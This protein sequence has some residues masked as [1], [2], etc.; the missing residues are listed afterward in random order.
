VD[1][2]DTAAYIL[3]WG[4]DEE[5]T[6][7][8]VFLVIYPR[9]IV[10]SGARPAEDFAARVRTFRSCKIA[11]SPLCILFYSL[12]KCMDLK[13]RMDSVC[14]TSSCRSFHISK[15]PQD[16]ESTLSHSGV[17]ISVINVL[18]MPLGRMQEVGLRYKRGHGE[19]KMPETWRER[20]SGA[21]T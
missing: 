10:V 1:G 9:L 11:I 5:R 17:V 18:P 13:W 20:T 14:K 16:F 7:V 8:R 15:W 19:A 21:W 12:P 2:S 4:V 6:A 3:K